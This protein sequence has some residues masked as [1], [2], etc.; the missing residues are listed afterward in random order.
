[1][2]NDSDWVCQLRGSL[3]ILGIARSTMS[4]D[5][6]MTILLQA[7]EMFQQ[8]R[9]QDIKEEVGALRGGLR[10]CGKEYV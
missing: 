6:T 1:M 3:E 7:E 8:G 2:I 10:G 5:E 9:S 4:T